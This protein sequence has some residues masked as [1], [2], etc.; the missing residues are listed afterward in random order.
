MDDISYL[1]SQGT[2]T[3]CQSK[4]AFW[5]KH[6]YDQLLAN[7]NNNHPSVQATKLFCEKSGF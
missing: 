7:F 6:F 1:L 5:K 2:K 4:S 3:A